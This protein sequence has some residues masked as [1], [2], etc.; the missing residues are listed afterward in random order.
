MH[1]TPPARGETD[2]AVLIVD[3][4][5]TY[6]TVMREVVEA[7]PGLRIAGEAD[8]GEAAI[9]AAQDLSVQLVIVDKRMPGM[10]GFET[11]RVITGATPGSP[12]SCARSRTP[13]GHREGHGAAAVMRKQDLSRAP[14][15]RVV[16]DPYAPPRRVT[17]GRGQ[18]RNRGDDAVPWPGCSTANVP[19]TASTRSRSPCRPEP[20]VSAAPPAPSSAT[21]TTTAEP[22]GRTLRRIA[23]RPRVLLGVGHR[24]GDDVVRASLRARGQTGAGAGP[25][26]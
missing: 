8:S 2:I 20:G 26:A 23:R 15:A 21:S 22:R 9:D 7:T 14:P 1:G 11:C 6:R 19:P 12:W 4:Q 13:P 16:I 25:R 24:L 10:G 18:D 17:R 5:P 3:D